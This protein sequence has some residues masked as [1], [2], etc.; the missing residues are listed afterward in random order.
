MADILKVE[1]NIKRSKRKTQ[2]YFDAAQEIGE[3]DIRIEVHF[4][5]SSLHFRR[6]WM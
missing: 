3:G 2:R 5:P 4:H 6:K 1:A